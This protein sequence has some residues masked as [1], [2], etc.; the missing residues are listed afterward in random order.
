VS[1]ILV[2]GATGQVGR[3]LRPRLRAAGHQ[4]IAVSRMAIPQSGGENWLCGDLESD[5]DIPSVDAIV[6]AGPLD[7]FAAWIARNRPDGVGH[8]VALSSM[9][10]ESKLGSPDPAERALA[11][12]LSEAEILLAAACA[13]YCSRWTILRPTLI[14]GAGLDRSLTPLVRFAWRTRLFPLV[15]GARG[16]RQPVHADDL[17]AA[18]AASL[19]KGAAAHEKIFPFGGGE[20]MSCAEMLRRVRASAGVATLPVPL[21]LALL[22]AGSRVIGRGLGTV[23]RFGDDLCADNTAVV[24]DLAVAP[25]PFRPLPADWGSAPRHG[26]DYAN[27]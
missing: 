5:V 8:V 16:L 15:P 13:A 10:A 12:H 22:R 4:V 1:R 11:Q 7:R 3:F 17:A 2:F 18:C 21:P 24:A 6:S 26:I 14:W 23:A 25:R 19:A 20:R 9:S 27:L